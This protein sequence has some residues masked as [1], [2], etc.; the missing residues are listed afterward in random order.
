MV[1]DLGVTHIVNCS[2]SQAPHAE[3]FVY[4][5]FNLTDTQGIF[6]HITTCYRL[7]NPPGDLTNYLIKHFAT[8]FDFVRNAG[9]MRGR[10][11]VVSEDSAA[12]AMVI[13]FMMVIPTRICQ[14]S[15]NH[16]RKTGA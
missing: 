4:L 2:N 6:F 12:A 1:N 9:K 11:L 5:N 7:L 15:L 16:Y 13:G 14:L 8:F 10:V 3:H